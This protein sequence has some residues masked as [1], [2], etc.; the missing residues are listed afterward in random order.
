MIGVLLF[1]YGMN[2][3]AG[4]LPEGILSGEYCNMMF[5]GE[6]VDAGERTFAISPTHPMI[7]EAISNIEIE[8]FNYYQLSERPK[9]GDIVVAITDKNDV[10]NKDWIF[11]ATSTDYKTLKLICPN[12]P[13][14]QDSSNMTFR[15]NQYIN[16]GKYIEAGEK[17]RAKQNKQIS[18]STSGPQQE[19]NNRNY[20]LYS[21]A[22]VIVL[23]ALVFIFKKR[24]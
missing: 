20:Y 12:D 2:V 6:I 22:G 13:N 9:V 4:D 10:I 17:L 19:A 11:K 15:Y 1:S 14:P 23:V 18:T 7:G 24:R 21:L 8:S 16:E 5:I 3:F